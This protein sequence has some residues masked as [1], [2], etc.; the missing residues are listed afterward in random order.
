MFDP[1]TDNR[2]EGD[3]TMLKRYFWA[4]PVGLGLGVVGAIVGFAMHAKNTIQVTACGTKLGEAHQLFSATFRAT[5]TSAKSM[6]ALGSGLIMVGGILAAV[7]V[8]I[9]I[10]HFVT[11]QN[12]GP[13]V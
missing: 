1:L 7:A 4:I 9:G 2:S 11:R 13:A 5:C 8:V 10:A 3:E 12:P 6:S